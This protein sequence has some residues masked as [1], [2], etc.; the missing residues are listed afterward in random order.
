MK[1]SPRE[2]GE[3]QHHVSP[4]SRGVIF[5]RARLSLAVLSLRENRDYS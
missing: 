5:R 2:K 4:F 1:I 3:T